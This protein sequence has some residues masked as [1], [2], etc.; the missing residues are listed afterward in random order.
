MHLVVVRVRVALHP[1]EIGAGTPHRNR[2]V[3]E[4]KRLRNRAGD[5]QQGQPVPARAQALDRLP[6]RPVLVDAL[7]RVLPA[8]P[9]LRVIPEVWLLAHTASRDGLFLSWPSVQVH[10]I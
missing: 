8:V 5:A 1:E 3:V 2:D 9:L 6:A 4:R 10:W 7:Q